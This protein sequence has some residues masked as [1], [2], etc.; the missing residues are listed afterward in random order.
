MLA[1]LID[2][3]GPNMFSVAVWVWLVDSGGRR[4]VGS[5]RGGA[6]STPSM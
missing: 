5:K 4:V 2:T 3:A 6:A 1:V